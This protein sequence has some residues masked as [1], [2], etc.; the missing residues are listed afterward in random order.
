MG[1]LLVTND[2]PPKIGGIQ[3]YLY[4]LWRRLPP[5]DVTVLTTA[6]QGADAFDRE[7]P[8]RIVRS[9]APVLLPNPGLARQVR[10]LA[11]ESSAGLVVWDPAF[12]LGL[13]APRLGLDYGVVLHGSEVTIPGRLPPT[14]P[15]LGRVVSAA[16]VVIAAGDYPATQARSAARGAPLAAVVIPPG[17]DVRAFRP[18][19][20]D[21]KLQARRSLG[22]PTAGPLVVSVSRL[23]PR[24][25]MDVLIEAVGLLKASM[26]DICLAIAG[27]GRE[28]K[29]LEAVGRRSR[30]DVVFLGSVSEEEKALLDGAA[31]VWAMLCRDRM[32]GWL[33]EGFGI[34]FMEAAACGVPQVAGDSGGARDAVVDGETGFVV[35][36]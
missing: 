15:L 14:R 19:S 17:V 1:H 35:A 34:V 6:Y 12:P 24:K 3:S 16:K 4:E 30:V 25:G 2:F 9:K 26:P 27:S 33:Q 23:V 13:L 8:F 28:L 18:L 7:Q 36:N 21:E 32:G 22:L 11:R 10:A 29:A 5:E 20:D 31:D